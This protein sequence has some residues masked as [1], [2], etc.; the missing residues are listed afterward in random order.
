MKLKST[1]TNARA[2]TSDLDFFEN[3][4]EMERGCVPVGAAD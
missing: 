3:A 4:M 2:Q 1:E